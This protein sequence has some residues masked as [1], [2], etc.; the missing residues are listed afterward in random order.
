[1]A[2]LIA[3]KYEILGKIGQ[4][5]MGTV[6]K[7]RHTTLDSVFALK[8]L[9]DISADNPE[10]VG[11]FQREARIMAKLKHDNIVRVFELAHERDVH[12]LVMDFIDGPTLAQH[13]RAVG[14]LSSLDALE[15]ARQIGR[16]LA[17]FRRHARLQP[18]EKSNRLP[19]ENLRQQRQAGS[20]HHHGRLSD[21]PCRS[22]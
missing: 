17:S 15:I 1:M 4:G 14:L 3:G 11:R 10:L 20:R 21:E 2:D 18:P 7:V 12:C 9:P 13:M 19:E 6:Y 8:V 16:A 5:G 22:T